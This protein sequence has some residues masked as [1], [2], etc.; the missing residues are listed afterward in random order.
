MLIITTCYVLFDQI[1]KYTKQKEL[2]ASLATYE[3]H[4]RVLKSENFTKISHPMESNFFY[5]NKPKEVK[6]PSYSDALKQRARSK[7]EKQ[8]ENVKFYCNNKMPQND[9]LRLSNERAMNKSKTLYFDFDYSFIYCL[10]QKVIR[11]IGC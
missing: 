7:N 9:Y 8:L 3:A 11:C 1:N 6:I 5:Q 2:P 10:I 4:S